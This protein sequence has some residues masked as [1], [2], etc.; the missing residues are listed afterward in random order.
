MWRTILDIYLIFIV[1][2]FV[3]KVFFADRKM[4][5]SFIFFIIVFGLSF[6]ASHFDLAGSKIIYSYI[7]DYGVIIL[8]IIL[9]PELRR[10]IE[11]SWQERSKKR[12][13]IMGSDDTKEIIID[14]TMELAKTSTGAIITIEKHNTLEVYAE[15]AVML[16]SS[17]SKELLLNIFTPNTPLHDGAVIV[18]GD[19][20]LCAG[21]YFVLTGREDFEKTMGSRHRAG[22]GISEVTD[23]FTIVVS[24]ET[25]SISIAIEGVML[26]INDREKLS[27]YLTVFMR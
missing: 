17:V 5:S 18:R 12:D 11:L 3:L 19:Q 20:I 7:R 2:Y 27:E 1:V 10:I 6:V 26:K 25:G 4:L 16:N 13:V 8:I 21:A 14:A 9:A 22:L 23:S 15:K 24:E